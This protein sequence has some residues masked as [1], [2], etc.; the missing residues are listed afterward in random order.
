MEK[1]INPF[2]R[3]TRPDVIAAARRFDAASVD[4]S[5]AF[6]TLRQWKNQYR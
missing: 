5:G 3:S 1:A 6:A 4:T 2:L